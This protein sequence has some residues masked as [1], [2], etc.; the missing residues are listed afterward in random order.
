V[1]FLVLKWARPE[2]DTTTGGSGNLGPGMG[3]RIM[4]VGKGPLGLGKG[5]DSVPSGHTQGNF[6]IFFPLSLLSRL[7]FHS[8]LYCSYRICLKYC[9]DYNKNLISHFIFSF[10]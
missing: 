10:F 7:T 8:L 6:S 4:Y 1:E 2:M 9:T 5:V 3:S